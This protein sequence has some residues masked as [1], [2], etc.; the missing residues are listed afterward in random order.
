[1]GGVGGGGQSHSVSLLQIAPRES[2][3]FSFRVDLVRRDFVCCRANRNK[4]S[5]RLPLEIKYTLQIENGSLGF[6][7]TLHKSQN[8]SPLAEIA[9]NLQEYRF[10][11][12]RK[13]LKSSSFL[14]DWSHFAKVGNTLSCFLFEATCL[15][16][17]HNFVF[18]TCSSNLCFERL[19]VSF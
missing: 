15:L 19:N 6:I 11:C 7:K 4:K 8:L 3:F 9:E 18:H 16:P 5:Q 14:L 1:M 13:T 12:K 2:R 17:L 10:L